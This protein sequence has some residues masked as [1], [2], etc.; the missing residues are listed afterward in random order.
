MPLSACYTRVPGLGLGQLAGPFGNF[1][2]LVGFE[3]LQ[4]EQLVLKQL[5][6]QKVPVK[7]GRLPAQHAAEGAPTWT[8]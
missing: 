7:V 5:G 8:A 1:Y 4:R 2:G 3:S 6:L